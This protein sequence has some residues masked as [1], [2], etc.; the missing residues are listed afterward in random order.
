MRPWCLMVALRSSKPKVR[1]QISQDAQI[2]RRMHMEL[3][4]DVVGYE[5]LFSISNYGRVYSNRTNKILKQSK[6]KSGY[7]TLATRINYKNH[8][9]RVHRLVAEAFLE[10]TFSK[11][12]V[13]HLDGNKEN[14]FKSNLVWVTGSENIQHAYDTGLKKA[15]RGLDNYNSKLTQEQV[16]Y[17]R[18]TYKPYCRLNGARAIAERLGVNHMQVSR[19][20]RR[21]S[22]K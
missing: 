9:F 11:P 17:I 5:A 20:F 15:K 12:E 4:K 13:N 19:V 3:W 6:N 8:C 18:D 2:Q 10:N 22:Y 7:L 16:D 21:V 1:V 14:N